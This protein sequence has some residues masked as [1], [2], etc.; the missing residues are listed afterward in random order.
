MAEL[1]RTLKQKAKHALWN[2][3]GLVRSITRTRS[4]LPINFASVR[5]VLVL[6]PDRLGDVVLSTPVYESIKLSFPKIHVTALIDRANTSIL[7][8]NPN[9]DEITELNRKRPLRIFQK[10]R[11]HH[12]DVIFTL[13]KKF[14]ATAS[15]LALTSR[16]NYR[17]GYA[18]K[19]THW[20][21]DVCVPTGGPPRH[22]ILNNLELLRT[23]GIH[24]VAEPP[25]LYFN[26][27]EARNV[28]SV[29]HETR[30]FPRRPLVL[31]KPGT[32][33]AEWG[34]PMEK[35]RAVT[36]RLIE[37]G[38][39]EALFICGPGEEAMID[40]LV[41]G[42]S[43]KINRLPVLSIKE[44]ALAIRKSDL[45]L[46]N[47]TGIMHLGSAVQTPVVVIFKHGE[48]ARWGPIHT[49]HAVLEE[50]GNDS[51]TPE[52][53]LENIDRLLDNDYTDK[54]THQPS[55]SGKPRHDE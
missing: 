20:L 35:F 26:E 8:G 28:E 13:N 12:F 51:L 36:G 47:H 37:S 29:L 55:I 32:R 45:L 18:H 11:R 14:S 21:Y 4:V 31:V 30:R 50:R 53:V 15:L 16:A 25:R 40:N 46:C 43:Q 27:T 10:L 39:A 24:K 22:E 42:M 2:I 23:A 48:I 3:I 34:W 44:L 7:T 54:R 1:A 49:R 38:K 9:I 33:I 52:T 5:S 6:R 19:E 17:I 41:H